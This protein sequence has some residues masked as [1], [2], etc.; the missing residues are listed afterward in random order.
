MP[1]AN[2]RKKTPKTVVTFASTQDAM[3]ME[4]AADAFGLPGRM[5]PVPSEVSAGCGL[6]WCAPESCR[7]E[8]LE[9]MAA[10]GLS[11]EGVFTVDLY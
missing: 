11:Y 8:M 10:H 3:D 9:D 1:I 6:A 5:I 4:E 2:S 7:E